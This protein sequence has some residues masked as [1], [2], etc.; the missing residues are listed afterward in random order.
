ML[1]ASFGNKETDLLPHDCTLFSA[2]TSTTY[3]RVDVEVL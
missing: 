3:L 1:Y 2:E